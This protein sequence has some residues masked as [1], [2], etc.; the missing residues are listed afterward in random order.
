MA[1]DGP[2]HHS[3][4]KNTPKS[5]LNFDHEVIDI[6]IIFT[7]LIEKSSH[8]STPGRSLP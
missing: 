7:N 2:I 6:G 5:V 3:A 8:Y 1:I 4:K